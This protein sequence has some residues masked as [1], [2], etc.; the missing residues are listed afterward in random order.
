VDTIFAVSSGAAPAAISILR[1]SGPGALAAG[2]ALCGTLP[3]ARQAR[4]RA[5]QD[6]HS[7]LLL[8]RGLVLVFPG[9]NSATGEDL[10]E[11]HV[12]GGRATQ[13]DYAPP[14]R[15]SSPAARSKMAAS[16]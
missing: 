16:I 10:V 9:P 4:V 1:I 8:D 5:L 11:L 2:E 3:A 14:S 7:K 6:P 12:H 15:V 13:R